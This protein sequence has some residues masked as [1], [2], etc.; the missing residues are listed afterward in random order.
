MRFAESAKTYEALSTLSDASKIRALRKAMEASFFQN[1]VAHLAKLIEEADKCIITDRLENARILMNKG[2]F[3]ALKGQPI[4][5]KYFADVLCVFEEEYALWDTAWDLIAFGTV[6]PSRGKQ[7]EALSTALRAIGLFQELGDSRWLVEAYNMAGLMLVVHFGF[8]QEGLRMLDNAEQLNESAKIGDYLRLAQINSVRAWAYS[9][10]N[11]PKTALS[12]S[13]VALQYANK[14][15][16][17]WGKGM[18]YA[19]L[20][21]EYTILGDIPQAEIYFNKLTKLPPEVHLNPY[22]NSQI[23]KAVLLAGK[24]QWEQS[25]QVF[26]SIFNHLKE[27]PNPGLEAIVRTCYA[28]A[29]LKRRN[30]LKAI[31]QIREARK[32]YKGIAERFAHINVQANMMAPAKVT[33][34]RNFEARLDLVNISRAKGTLTKIEN[35][36]ASGLSFESASSE[37]MVE[38]GSIKLNDKSIEPLTIITVKLKFKPKTAGKFYIAPTLIYKN[39]VGETETTHIKPLSINVISTDKERKMESTEDSLREKIDFKS[40]NAQN[41]FDYLLRSFKE[42]YK[43]HRMPE[44]KSGW[45]TFM[46]IVR[47]GKV[48][49]YSVYGSSGG[50]GHVIAEMERMG[51]VE[52]RTFTGERGRGG[53]VLKIKIAHNKDSVR[54]LLVNNR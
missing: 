49:K 41:A 10:M 9:I 51:I 32:F 45:R 6:L 14:T 18:A 24:K 47:D 27:N 25:R 50:Y 30:L 38:N 3:F 28:W 21:M 23:A 42:D 53:E 43:N 52:I 15:D 17:D 16:S 54:N 34:D 36:S 8:S 37:F 13:L 40:Q 20:T 26:D 5:E 2:R 12:K 1:D 29:L 19:N 35:L 31:S 4:S 44:E 11:D 48:P 22:V 33:T 7:E 46:D 39:D